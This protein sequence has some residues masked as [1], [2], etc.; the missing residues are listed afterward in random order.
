MNKKYK[1]IIAGVIGIIIL[2]T[3]SFFIYRNLSANKIVKKGIELM[4]KKE[5]NKSIAAFDLA[6]D[7][8]PNDKEVLES[9][10]MI[11][12]YLE[13]KKLF[14]EGK[15]EEANKEVIEISRNYSN[16]NG[17]NKD[18]DSLKAEINESIK[19]DTETSNNIN[20]VRELVKVKK[21]DEGKKLIDGLG[22]E[23]LSE[24]QTQQI[25]DL[26][27]VISSELSRIEY[28]GK[29]KVAAAAAEAEAKK[30][31]TTSTSSNN[32]TTS[33][34]QPK[35]YDLVMSVTNLDND[36]EL[37]FIGVIKIESSS[38]IPS[39]AR[40]KTAYFFEVAE[41]AA[42]YVDMQG[43]VYRNTAPSDGKCIKLR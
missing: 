28:E 33:I 14:D 39:E 29:A 1:L 3:G 43:H 38:Y 24:N 32:N 23:K 19:K 8:K 6:L 41:S 2:G 4:T 9:K 10:D 31:A 18:V 15:T 27:S 40:G 36:A 17:F 25:E 5:Y 21:Y 13:A 12:K 34:T 37:V 30:K 26:K 20:K 22:K 42:Y 11:E 16:F 35:A 7:D